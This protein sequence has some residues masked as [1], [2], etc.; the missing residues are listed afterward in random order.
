MCFRDRTIGLVVDQMEGGE[1]KGKIKSD[2]QS[3]LIPLYEGDTGGDTG[4]MG[5]INQF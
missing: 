2:S 3:L 1:E 4:F 5:W